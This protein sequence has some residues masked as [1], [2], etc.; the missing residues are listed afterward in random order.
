MYTTNDQTM[1]K[2]LSAEDCRLIAR[3]ILKACSN[4]GNLQVHFVSWWDGSH[5]WARNSIWDSNDQRNTEISIRREVD[6]RLGGV[7]VNQIDEIS[8][9][10]AV[11]FAESVAEMNPSITGKYEEMLP[12]PPHLGKINMLT[13]DDN[14]FR[15]AA[16]ERTDII[17]PLISR[18]E[19]SG[20]LAAGDISMRAG[21]IAQLSIGSGFSDYDHKQTSVRYL[22]SLTKLPIT[23][24]RFTAADCSITVRSPLGTGSGWA[25][26]SSF[27]W[28]NVNPR[29]VADQSFEKCIAS[30][31]PVRIEP[32]RYVTILEPQ[33]VAE[34]IFIL[35]DSFQRGRE[36]AEI[37][38]GGRWVLGYDNALM[39]WRSK[40]GIKII[41]QRITISHELN[42]SRLGYLAPPGTQDVIWVEKGVL[43]TLDS[44]RTRYLIPHLNS[45]TSAS[46]RETFR[47]SGGTSTIESM[48]SE[49]QRGLIVTSFSQ[50]R[51]IHE[52]SLLYTGITRNGL[53][54]VEDGKVSRAAQNMR[55]TESP[56]FALNQV[57]SLG[58]PVP[59]FK[60][61]TRTQLRPQIVPAMRIS[62]F[63]FTSVND[64]I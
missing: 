41:D 29:E 57:L 18:A 34:L 8:L 1:D 53:W 59:I 50:I 39:R 6:G 61:A 15:F 2:I 30:L 44:D 58:S 27:G 16:E 45:N 51:S 52:P 12:T 13:W 49:T 23:Y 4:K 64:S 28:K 5:K 24:E 63:S 9:D 43:K 3:K 38:G 55:F 36:S 33:A 11:K 56:L 46:Y 48:I 54:L 20:M 47:V 22:R 35:V 42:D 19:R 25:G 21:A 37:Y 40:L 10:A 32:G 62:D 7:G 60:P 31:D 26:A 17:N 14:T